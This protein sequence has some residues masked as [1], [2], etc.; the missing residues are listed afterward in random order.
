[1]HIPAHLHTMAR[2][3]RKG[4]RRRGSRGDADPDPEP[5]ANHPDSDSDSDA[6]GSDGGQD[7]P[8]S[9]EPDFAER[10]ERQRREA[11]ERRRARMRCH[12]CGL[13]GHVRR[14][15]PG[16]A[17]DGRGES[18][19]KNAKGDRGA[20]TRGKASVK[21]A[22]NRGRRTSKSFDEGSP[23]DPALPDGF[24]ARPAAAAE[25]AAGAQDEAEAGMGEDGGP[26]QPHFRYI[27][28]GCDAAATV[29]YLRTGRGK[30][31]L[32][33]REAVKEYQGA[34][35]RANSASNFGG[36]LARCA[37]PPGGRPW[38]PEGAFPLHL[39]AGRVW[40]V[41]GPGGGPATGFDA[42]ALRAS[43]EA[44]RDRVAGVFADLDYGPGSA[45]AD[46]TGSCREDQLDRL[47]AVID[48][49]AGCGCPV[50]I[51]TLPAWA[52]PRKGSADGGSERGGGVEANGTDAAEDASPYHRAIGDLGRVLLEAVTA[53]PTLRVHL[54]C[55][56]GRSDH[57]LALLGA[58]PANAYAGL[59]ATV[60]HSKATEAHAV[61]FDVPL[62]RLLLET[63]A[64]GTVPSAAARAAGRAAF[65]HSG[66]LPLVAEAVAF[67][68]GG[69]ADG[70]GGG[71]T[72]AEVARAASDNVARLYP[73]VGTVY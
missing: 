12:V 23:A 19:Y 40:Y 71:P 3:P 28:A 35:D 69:G 44:H 9:G 10:R 15:C 54:S 22:R 65:G 47:R 29:Q 52:P 33:L 70:P 37:L 50:Q 20:R 53:H 16:I 68:K 30:K 55:W 72:A 51:R 32:S 60:T 41:L 8:S 1:M 2:G 6:G 63:G 39:E 4:R 38:E 24:E 56:T 7:L 49:A 27:D 46:G 34:I 67:R 73:N 58:F 11:A 45:A 48:V 13:S 62:S 64:P 42:A 66:L 61:A 21:G 57:L 43:V 14:E 31:K 36:C 25:A 26:R 17:D 5:D 59:D 18:R